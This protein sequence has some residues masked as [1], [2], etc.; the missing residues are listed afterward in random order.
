MPRLASGPEAPISSPRGA[1]TCAGAR[2]RSE[3]LPRRGSWACRAAVGLRGTAAAWSVEA[4][5][6]G[7]CTT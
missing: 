1:C 4:L 6:L 7:A 2:G 3:P 5:L